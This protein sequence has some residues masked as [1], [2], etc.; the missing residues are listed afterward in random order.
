MKEGVMP[1]EKFYSQYA[2]EGDGSKPELTVSW[3]EISP[4]VFINGT[5]FDRSALNRLIR[6]LTKAR[7][8]TYGA[9]E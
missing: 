2:V 7:N 4:E 1:K 9:D 6:T 8:A 5:S 3:G